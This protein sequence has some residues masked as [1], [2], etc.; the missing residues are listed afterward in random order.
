MNTIEEQTG[1]PFKQWDQAIDII[2]NDLNEIRKKT[3]GDPQKDI[4]AAPTETKP[5]FKIGDLAYYRTERP[6]NALGE[7][8]P[9]NNFREGDYRFNIKDPKTIKA[10]LYYPK[11]II[12]C[13]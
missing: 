6:M 7:F 12:K 1:K 2:R 3:D 10:I 5:K 9:T 11:N 4:F 13:Y 8:Q